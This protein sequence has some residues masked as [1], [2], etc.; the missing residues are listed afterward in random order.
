MR[1]LV[2]NTFGPPKSGMLL[3]LPDNADYGDSQ[4]SVPQYM[5]SCEISQKT[6]M[7]FCFVECSY[8]LF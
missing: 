6:E 5:L 2:A 7:S 1:R 4:K 3:V 8:S